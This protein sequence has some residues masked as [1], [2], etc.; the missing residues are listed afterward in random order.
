[1]FF[2]FYIILGLTPSIVWLLFYLRKDVHPEP[3]KQVI[4]IFLWGIIIAFVVIWIELALAWFSSQVPIKIL[5]SLFSIFIGVALVEEYFKYL[6]VKVK[7]IRQAEFDEPMDAMIYMII[8]GLGFAALEN[9]LIIVPI[10]Q[11]LSLSSSYA[12]LSTEGAITVTFIRFISATL[13]HAL[14][15]GTLGYFIALSFYNIRSRKK[16]I[17]SGL[18]LVAL[19]HGFYN[20][21]IMNID[22]GV[23]FIFPVII[24]LTLIAL[25]TILFKKVKKLSSTCKIKN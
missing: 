10:P 5:S 4:R 8:A 15:S 6:V 3:K 13:L 23:N 22:K 14:C 9:I 19:L 20:L 18:V 2:L 24:L 16:I 7:I 11:F 12:P 25:T 1:M 21:G 17:G